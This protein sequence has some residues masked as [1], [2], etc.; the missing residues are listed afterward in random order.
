MSKVCN[1]AW[2]VVSIQ[3]STTV[4]KQSLGLMMVV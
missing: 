1:M 4:H 3:D 2:N